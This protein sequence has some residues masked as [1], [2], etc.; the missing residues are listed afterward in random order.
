MGVLT[1]TLY[2]G[3]EVLLTGRCSEPKYNETSKVLS[4]GMATS[5]KFQETN[6]TEWANCIAFGK[7]AEQMHGKFEKGDTI[8]CKGILR[9]AKPREG[10]Q[11][12]ENKKVVFVG[13]LLAV[14]K[15][16]GQTPSVS[17]DQ[18]ADGDLPF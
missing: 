8:V 3:F 2:P 7:D 1:P 5:V 14:Q 10:E 9:T 17:Q 12:D 18:E 6:I 11:K 15:K 13:S 4:W 16:S